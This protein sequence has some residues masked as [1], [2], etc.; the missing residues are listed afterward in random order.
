MAKT[1]EN[2]TAIGN[3]RLDGIINK[4]E[5]GILEDWNLLGDTGEQQI[6]KFEEV[7]KW[8]LHRSEEDISTVGFIMGVRWAIREIK[9]EL[10]N[11]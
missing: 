10:K 6:E 7:Q 2:P 9:K 1:Y 4:L 5:N 8:S 3:R 11:K